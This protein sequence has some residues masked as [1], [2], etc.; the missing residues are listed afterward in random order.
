MAEKKI[1][2]ALSGGG[3]RG[4]SHVGVLR[5]LV[6]NGVRIDMIAGT[7]AGSIV[8]GAFAAGMSIEAIEQMSARVRWGNMLRP[9]LSPLGLLSTAPMGRFLEHELP[10]ARFEQLAIPYAAVVCDF[11]TGEERVFSG[12]GDLIFAIRASCSVPGVFTPMR[13]ADGLLLIDGGVV[14][15]TPTAAV[16]AMGADVVIAVDLIACGASFRTQPRSAFGILMGSAMRLLSVASIQQS[17]NAD[18][19]I[20]PQIAHLRPDQIDKRDEFISLG[21][22]AALDAMDRIKEVTSEG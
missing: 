5:A 18:V 9:S 3:A 10:V 22:A 11:A 21:E 2:L 16:R 15:P 14:S 6:E 7:S 1:G 17:N 19:T 20:V 8:G 4:F 12:E 13:D